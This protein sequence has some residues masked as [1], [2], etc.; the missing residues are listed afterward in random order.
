M[1]LSGEDRD[2]KLLEIREDGVQ[3]KDTIMWVVSGI[4]YKF[5]LQL[6]VGK[7]LMHAVPQFPS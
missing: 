7:L 2:P 5:P 3:E 4:R 1:R 6:K